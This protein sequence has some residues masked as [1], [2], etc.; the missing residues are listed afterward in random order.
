MIAFALAK[1]EALKKLPASYDAEVQGL[2]LTAVHFSGRHHSGERIL[3]DLEGGMLKKVGGTGLR[4]NHYV[5][6]R[7]RSI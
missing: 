2:T 4:P 7:V 1:T 5:Q 6:R 3:A